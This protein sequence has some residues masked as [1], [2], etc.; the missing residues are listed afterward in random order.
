MNTDQ[1][2]NNPTVANH[3]SLALQAAIEQGLLHES[4]PHIALVNIEGINQTVEALKAA[5]PDSTRHCFAVKANPYR[6]ILKVLKKAGVGAEVASATE[7]E[8]VIKAKFP[9]QQIIF[10]APVK[11]SQDINRALSLGI[12]LNIDN[13]QEL[14]RIESWF[15]EN[16][17][18]SNIGFRINPQI[19]SGSV[20]STSTATLTSK[21]GIGLNDANAKE[22]IIQ[23][24]KKNDWITALHV[25]VG[26][27]ACPISLMVDGVKALH[28]L[29]EEIN[30]SIDETRDETRI[31]KLDI[32]GGLPVN[33]DHDD[34]PDFLEYSQA[35]QQAIPSI[36]NDKYQLTTEFGRALMAK[37]AFSIGRV[38]YT[39][40]TGG[41]QI[42]LT[43]L[44]VQTLTRTVYDPVFWKRRL[45]VFS[46]QGIQKTG[47]ET[48]QDIAGP[49]CFSG[50]LI[51]KK[52]SLPLVE[53]SD[54]IMV[55]DT[56]SYHFSSHY[57]Y[58]ALPRLPVFA[59]Q[60]DDSGQV[61]FKCFSRG[62]NIMNVIDDYS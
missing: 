35:L 19:G 51:A 43:H 11:T 8:L 24:C 46:A 20:A 29:A 7:L 9:T 6:K 36:F 37:N 4:Q 32:G 52:R 30:S 54:Y 57:Q 53:P 3:K 10:D 14:E 44:G 50:D 55:H 42:A 59:Y 16:T 15:E 47:N 48:E 2:L 13:F 23:A 49:A 38:E 45:S 56:G 21:F 22:K 39:K 33:F 58:N 41:R 60:I 28:K 62:Q 17:S 1:P 26:S 31:N 34:L 18:T 25:H 12:D 40:N 27:V 61:K 5:F